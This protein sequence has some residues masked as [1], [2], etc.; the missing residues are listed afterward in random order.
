MEYLFGLILWFTFCI[1]VAEYGKNKTT[2]WW[3]AFLLSVF[4]S[5]LI[6]LIIVLLSNEKE[7]SLNK[8]ILELTA[9]A[10]KLK[11]INIDKTIAIMSKAL[12]IDP[13]CSNTHYNLGCYYSLKKNKQKSFKHISRAV[14]LNFPNIQQIGTDP[15]LVWMRSLP[16]FKT[17]VEDGYRLNTKEKEQKIDQ[18][19]ILEL[20]ELSKLKNE[21][22]LTEEEFQS[23]KDK[24]LR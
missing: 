16:E 1:L 7:K 17:F 15:D 21:G 20:R 11:K 2:G 9:E 19:Y 3:G 6:G 22:I 23:K 12:Q 8:D 10:D 4:L 14:E 13:N 5:P 18:G 24:I